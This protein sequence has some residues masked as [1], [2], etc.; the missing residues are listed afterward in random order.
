MQ[1]FFRAFLF[2][3]AILVL[4]ASF[5][6][7]SMASIRK[8]FAGYNRYDILNAE[9]KYS[10]TFKAGPGTLYE[11]IVLSVEGM[12]ATVYSVD[13]KKRLITALRFNESYHACIDTTTVGILIRPKDAESS[14]VIV[15]SGNYDLAEFVAGKLF[16]DLKK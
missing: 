9:K 1:I 10:E 8:E 11:K 4:S 5:Y 15:A 7:C 2:G 3:T 6:G 13:S 12:K 14:E 16:E